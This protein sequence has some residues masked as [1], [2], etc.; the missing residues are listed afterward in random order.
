MGFSKEP[1]V[2]EADERRVQASLIDNAGVQKGRLDIFRG[3][4]DK[5]DQ[6]ILHLR[7]YDN[8][9]TLSDHLRFSIVHLK[10]ELAN[11]K[12]VAEAEGGD[13]TVIHGTDDQRSREYMAKLTKD[14]RLKATLTWKNAAMDVWEVDVS[15]DEFKKAVEKAARKPRAKASKK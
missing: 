7:D 4:R 13:S 5:D 1:A 3:N 12:T 11:L 9:C 10:E 2:Y 15:Y 14:G 8:D 6:I